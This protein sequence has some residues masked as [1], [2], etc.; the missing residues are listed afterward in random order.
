MKLICRILLHTEVATNLTRGRALVLL[1]HILFESSDIVGQLGV[2]EI[3]N[4]TLEL[5]LL[6]EA[7]Q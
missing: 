3:D 5:G 1:G 2:T 4:T 6:Y 7:A